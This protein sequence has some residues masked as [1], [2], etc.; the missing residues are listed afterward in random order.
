MV[1]M[2]LESLCTNIIHRE[3][4]EAL[5]HYLQLRPEEIMPPTDYLVQLTELTLNNNVFLFQDKLYRQ[6]KSTAIGACFAPS[7]ANLY[8]GRLE[9][10][11]ILC[12]ANPFYEKIK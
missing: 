12:P 2:D 8:L 1:T 7:Y 3:G 11:H 10:L 4:L 5:Q 6:Q 9:E